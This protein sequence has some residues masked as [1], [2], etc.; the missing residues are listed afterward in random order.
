M[1]DP[2]YCDERMYLQVLSLVCWVLLVVES[3]GYED[4]SDECLIFVVYDGLEHAVMSLMP[5]IYVL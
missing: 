3:L 2:F 4:L 5:H 1:G